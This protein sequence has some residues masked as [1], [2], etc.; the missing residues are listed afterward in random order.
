M[1]IYRADSWRMLTITRRP[2][3]VGAE[4]IGQNYDLIAYICIVYVLYNIV[5]VA[6][7]ITP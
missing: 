6:P 1:H 5:C 3:P 2:W 4:D 7:C